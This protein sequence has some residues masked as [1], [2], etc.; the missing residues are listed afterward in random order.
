[1]QIAYK[2]NRI[3]ARFS[4]A[5][6]DKGLDLLK[7]LAPEQAAALLKGDFS[8]KLGLQLLTRNPGLV[9]T[10]AK[11]SLQGLLPPKLAAGRV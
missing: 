9:R 6:W 11:Y 4:D 1:M 2:I 7:H 3:I 10:L 5:Q 8:A